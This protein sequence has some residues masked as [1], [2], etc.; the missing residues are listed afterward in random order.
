[1]SKGNTIKKHNLREL[2]RDDAAVEKMSEAFSELRADFELDLDLNSKQ[3]NELSK[4]HVESNDHLQNLS[5]IAKSSS[6]VVSGLRGTGKTHLFLL[7]RHSINK[8]FPKDNHFCA[9]I[10][11]KRLS[12]PIESDQDTFNRILA[13]FIYEEL[14]K[15]LTSELKNA[16]PRGF[17]SHIT[18]LIDSEQ[19]K[20]L[21]RLNAAIEILTSAAEST[22]SGNRTIDGIGEFTT[23]LNSQ[24]EQ[25]HEAL[26]EASAKLGIASLSTSISSTRKNLLKKNSGTDKSSKG[27]T[28]FDVRSTHSALKSV[29]ETLELKSLT[30]FFDEWE[31]IYQPSH[32]QRWTADFINRTNDNPLY[33]WIAFVPHRG[34]L[35]PLSVGGDL[36]HLINLDADLIIE[37]SKIDRARCVEYFSEFVDKRL[38]LHL[39]GH[40]ISIRTL[41][42]TSD[43]LELLIFGS[44]GNTRDFGTILL[45]AWQNYKRYRLGKMK[46]GKPFQYITDSQIRDAIKADGIKK[47]SNISND[48]SAMSAWSHVVDFLTS[49]R[50]SH[51]AMQ[52]ARIQLDALSQ[53]EMSELIYQRLV[54]IRKKGVEPKDQGGPKLTILAGSYSATIDLHGKSINFVKEYSAIDN[55]VRRYI[56]NLDDIVKQIR[57][58]QGQVHPCMN[59]S[60]SID[61]GR[62]KAAWEK[63]SCPF[64][65]NAIHN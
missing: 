2:V 61:I 42:N 60:A 1:M 31:K 28:F 51:M 15:Q 24:V 59:C 40:P 27:Q 26:E 8:S 50:S 62:M 41:V 33:F 45:D 52:E 65:G 49:R 25:A 44:M 6:G 7:A 10:N 34:S 14:I 36:Q 47:V 29:V 46:Q 5:T 43:K 22:L 63:N 19:K 37:N 13:L 18:S 3:I 16:S 20:L 54:F 38:Q 39:P 17:I 53:P 4:L 58:A 21:N 9:Y 57:T 64:C 48:A 23:R 30:F 12:F 35:N 56:I 55:K 32:I 11:L